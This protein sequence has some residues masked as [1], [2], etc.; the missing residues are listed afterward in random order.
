MAKEEKFELEDL[1]GVGDKTAEL[2]REAGFRNYM[3]IA[4]ASTAEIADIAG[5]SKKSAAKIISEARRKLKIGFESAANIWKIRQEIHRLTTGS[6]A[7]DKLLGGGI[8]TQALTE[9]AGAY[10]GGKTQLSHQ[11]AVN[12]QL[13][14]ERGGLN[15]KAVFIDAEGTFRP[16]RI[17]QM[18]EALNLNPNQILKGIKVARAFNTDHQMLLAEKVSDLIEEGLNV[19]L[20]VIDSLTGHFRAEYIGRGTLAERQQKLNRHLHTLQRLADVHNLAVVYTNQVL[21]RPDV[22]FG[23]PTQAAGGHI[24]SH[25]STYRLFLRRSK[26]DKRIVTLSDAPS[27]PYSECVIMITPEGIRDA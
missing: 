24:L 11:L 19:K 17:I 22:F 4:V 15:G 3:S 26:G 13:P 21:A 5:I 23:D 9:I 1:P 16:E 2:L 7:L 27:L 25:A 8:E 10:A 14:E 6:K 12:V 20:I 18:A